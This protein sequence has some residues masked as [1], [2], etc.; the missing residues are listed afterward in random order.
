MHRNLLQLAA[1]QPPRGRQRVWVSRRVPRLETRYW[2]PGAGFIA[3]SQVNRYR[4]KP[5]A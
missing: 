5:E 2:I 1:P 4:L 3:P